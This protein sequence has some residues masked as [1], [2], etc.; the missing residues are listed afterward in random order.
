MVG[1]VKMKLELISMFGKKVA[2]I[3]KMAKNARICRAFREK[4]LVSILE[5]LS[6]LKAVGLEK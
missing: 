1:Y 4:K 3:R 6:H 5:S 2:R